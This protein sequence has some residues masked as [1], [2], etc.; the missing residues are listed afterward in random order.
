[1]NCHNGFDTLIKFTLRKPLLEVHRNDSGLPVMTVDNLRPKTDYG[2]YGQCRLREKYKLCNFADM[3]V[4][5]RLKTTEHFFIVNKIIC[6]SV[7]LC[8]QHTYILV[9]THEIHIEMRSILHQ[10]FHMV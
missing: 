9:L 10:G 7:I 6:D 1:M 2:Q 5:I 4:T 3:I 8:L